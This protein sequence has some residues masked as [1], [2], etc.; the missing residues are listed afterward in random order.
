[1]IRCRP[2]P[3]LP[4]YA[5]ASI[6][7]ADDIQIF[8]PLNLKTKISLQPL[9]DCLNYLKSWMNSNFLK[10]NNNK[11]EVIVFGHS[12]LQDVDTLGPLAPNIHSTVKCLC[13]HFDRVFKFKKQISSVVRC[14]FFQLRLQAIKAYLPQ[15]HLEMVIH[16]FITSHLDYCNSLCVTN[17]QLNTCSSSK[18]LLLASWHGRKRE[19]ISHLCCTPYTGFLF[20]TGLILKSYC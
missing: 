9:L 13:V 11:A 17:P 18:M 12:E 15:K 6:C 10:L 1:M 3:I 20:V 8:L 14:S 19:T 4:L 7:F 16:A 2:C 5:A